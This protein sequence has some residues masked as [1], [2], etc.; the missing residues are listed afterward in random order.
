M[1]GASTASDC[2]PATSEKWQD[3]P[4]QMLLSSP[5]CLC[6]PPLTQCSGH[7]EQGRTN[8]SSIFFVPTSPQTLDSSHKDALPVLV[9]NSPPVNLRVVQQV[10][11]LIAL[12]REFLRIVRLVV[13]QGNDQGFFMFVERSLEEGDNKIK[14]RCRKDINCRARSASP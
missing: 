14:Q 4:Q 12:Q 11:L 6:Y 8:H 7:A 2:L 9:L 13:I 5:F 3:I 10:V 1:Q